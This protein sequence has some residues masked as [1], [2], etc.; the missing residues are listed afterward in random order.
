[1]HFLK[2]KRLS[3]IKEEIRQKF[4]PFTSRKPQT[5]NKEHRASRQLSQHSKW[6]LFQ[7][8]NSL[9]NKKKERKG[10]V[11][12]TNNLSSLDPREENLCRAPL[13]P[14]AIW[15]TPL[16]T[17]LG[18]GGAPRGAVERTHPVSTFLPFAALP[19][20]EPAEPLFC[21]ACSPVLGALSRS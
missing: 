3:K 19:L 2:W 7:Q 13:L 5:G 12:F 15:P 18:P 6:R 4:P 11:F 20:T 17:K 9:E 10:S 14:P 8:W 16:P 1:M 21:A